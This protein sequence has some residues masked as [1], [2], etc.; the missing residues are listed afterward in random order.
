[1]YLNVILFELTPFDIC[2]VSLQ[3]SR[4]NSE[5]NFIKS[6]GNFIKSKGFILIGCS[7][8]VLCSNIGHFCCL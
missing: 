8:I 5:E 6:K 1:M 3:F 7:F 4:I 2:K